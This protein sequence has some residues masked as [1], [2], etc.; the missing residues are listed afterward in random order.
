MVLRLSARAVSGRRVVSTLAADAVFCLA[1]AADEGREGVC[2]PLALPWMEDIDVL[3]CPAMS[4]T[5]MR[6]DDPARK[7]P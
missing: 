1:Q 6:D 5:W 2:M 7:S 3:R 4:V